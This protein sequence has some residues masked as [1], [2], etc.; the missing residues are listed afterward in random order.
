MATKTRTS[1]IGTLIVVGIVA[2]IASMLGGW[3]INPDSPLRH[4]KEEHVVLTVR[5]TPPINDKG[6]HIIVHVEGVEIINYLGARSPWTHAQWIP[7]GAQVSLMA[8]QSTPDMVMCQI[9]SNTHL[10]D[11]NV[12]KDRLGSARCWHNRKT[13]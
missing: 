13:R 3:P 7:K 12:I 5:F 10:M 9:T 4:D 1:F 8:Q 2:G 6:I 11:S